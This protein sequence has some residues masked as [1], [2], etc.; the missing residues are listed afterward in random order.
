VFTRRLTRQVR[1]RIA[2]ATRSARSVCFLI[3]R[4]FVV[5]A[6]P[7]EAGVAAAIQECLGDR[8]N[9]IHAAIGWNLVELAALL[10]DTAFFVGDDTGAMNLAAA[11]GIRIYCLFGATQP[12]RHSSA[13]VPIL[14]PDGRPEIATGM[15]R[16]TTKAVLEAIITD[17]GI[18][19]PI[20]R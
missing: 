18:I 14:P 1:N 16:I 15:A 17:R 6:G 2:M 12:F 4:R 7:P 11:V 19:G 5:V 3:D 13:I 10:A 8:G 20:A 9:R